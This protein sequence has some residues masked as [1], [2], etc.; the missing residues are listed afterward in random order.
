MPHVRGRTGSNGCQPCQAIRLGGRTSSSCRHTHRRR[1][2]ASATSNVPPAAGRDAL[3]RRGRQVL[4]GSGEEVRV[5]TPV[6]AGRKVGRVEGRRWRCVPQPHPTPVGRRSRP[7]RQAARDQRRRDERD[8]NRRLQADP[9][10][11]STVDS[12]AFHR[13]TL[14]QFWLC[15]LRPRSVFYHSQSPHAVTLIRVSARTHGRV[16]AHAHHGSLQ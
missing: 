1:A 13:P 14:P 15:A 10:W 3:R 6:S 9:Q 11:R 7:T 2:L 8:E 5:D 4:Q 12:L 16:D